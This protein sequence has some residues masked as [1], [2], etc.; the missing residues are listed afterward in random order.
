MPS[1]KQPKHIAPSLQLDL[2]ML[3][4]CIGLLGLDK[5]T[6]QKPYKVQV[7]AYTLED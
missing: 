3:V 1:T 5:T 2:E 4:V 7:N 6:L